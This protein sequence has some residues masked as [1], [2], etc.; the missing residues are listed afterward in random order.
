M[1]ATSDVEGIGR[2]ISLIFSII[3]TVIALIIIVGAL[4][5]MFFKTE[6]ESKEVTKDRRIAGAIV[7]GFAVLTIIVVWIIDWLAHR[8][9][10]LAGVEGA[11]GVIA[12]V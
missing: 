7:A 5:L 1:S 4:L 3:V 9:R 8:S 10:I 11:G 2:G 6:N 12:M